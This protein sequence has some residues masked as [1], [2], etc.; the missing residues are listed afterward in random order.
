MASHYFLKIY[1][2]KGNIY[3]IDE[4]LKSIR[5]QLCKYYLMDFKA[6]RKYFSEILIM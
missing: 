6:T 5:A 4:S 3:E 2:L 1:L